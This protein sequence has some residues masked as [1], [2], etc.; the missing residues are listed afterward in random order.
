MIRRDDLAMLAAMIDHPD[1]TIIQVSYRDL[2]TQPRRAAKTE[3][4]TN[5]S[6]VPKTD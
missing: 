3:E 5:A 6:A 1:C 4:K 2:S